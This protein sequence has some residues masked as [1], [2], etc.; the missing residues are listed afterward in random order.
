MIS[1][2]AIKMGKEALVA[3]GRQYFII[4]LRK[5]VTSFNFEIQSLNEI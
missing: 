4:L 5:S 1:V 2:A 3:L